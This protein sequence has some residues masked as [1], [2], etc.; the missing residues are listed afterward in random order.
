VHK[1]VKT[2]IK[3]YAALHDEGGARLAFKAHYHGSSELE[4]IETT[5][6]SRLDTLV[7]RSEKPRYNFETHVSMHRKSR[8]DLEK[9]AGQV[10]PGPTK[11]RRLLKSLQ[12][13]KM[14][15]PIGTIRAIEY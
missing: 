1:H 13:S 3:L 5:A 14:A 2:W 6:E 15:I 12:A 4:Y 9:A 10:I 8:L 11:V 7:Y